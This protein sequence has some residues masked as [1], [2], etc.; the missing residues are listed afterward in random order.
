MYVEDSYTIYLTRLVSIISV[1]LAA[2]PLAS[3]FLSQWSHKG[4]EEKQDRFLQERAVGEE[5]Q[6]TIATPCVL[7]EKNHWRHCSAGPAASCYVT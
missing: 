1:L 4:T 6:L 2:E 3:H 7:L 5:E